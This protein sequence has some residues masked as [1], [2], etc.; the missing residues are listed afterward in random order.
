MEVNQAAFAATGRRVIAEV[1]EPLEQ[2]AT[3]NPEE[4]FKRRLLYQNGLNRNSVLH[5][6]STNYPSYINS[7][8]ALS[9]LQYMI[10]MKQHFDMLEDI[11]Q[12]GP[13]F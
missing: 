13:S 12:S 4:P 10:W 7:C 2:L 6:E 11:R 1:I 8:K 3:P 9:W 5:G